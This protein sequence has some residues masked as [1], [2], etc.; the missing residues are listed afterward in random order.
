VRALDGELP[1]QP[2]VTLAACIGIRGDQRDEQAAVANLPSDQRIPGIASPQLALIEL[3]FDP[4]GAQSFAQAQR[5]IGVLGGVA[6]EHR[7]ARVGHGAPVAS[8]RS[9]IQG[10][11]VSRPI[12]YLK[13]W[14]AASRWLLRGR[15]CRGAKFPAAARAASASGGA[16]RNL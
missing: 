3:H 16:S 4:R 2:E 7:L 15:A 6:Q 8:A 11:F 9:V 1:L 14:A 12:A 10:L 5:G 13:A